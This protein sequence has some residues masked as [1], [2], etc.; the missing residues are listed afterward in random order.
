MI[1]SAQPQPTA[2]GRDPV[3]TQRR[4]REAP[5]RVNP[6]A[7]QCHASWILRLL[8]SPNGAA[9]ATSLIDWE[10]LLHTARSNGVLVRTAE[11]LATLGARVP[12]TFA[13]A[14][15]LERARVHST[16]ELVRHVSQTCEAHGVEF[17]FPKLFQD[18]PDMGDDVDLLVLDRSSRVDRWIVA[19][20]ETSAARRDLGEWMAGTVTYAIR[21]CP[22]PL[23]VQHGRL[24]V[25]GE[26]NAFP[27][28]LMQNQRRIIV[29][30]AEFFAPPPEQQ[31]VL[32]GLQRVAGRRRI[33]LCDV[34]FTITAICRDPLDWDWIIGLARQHGV[35]LGLSCYLSYVD[36]IY[37][38]VF[39]HE[40]LPAAVRRALV[41]AGWGRVEFRQ[42]GYRFPLF[43][44]NRRLYLEQLGTR[45]ADADWAGAG[46][47][48]LIPVVA[49]WR[50]L[51]GLARS[52]TQ[53]KQLP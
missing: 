50:G 18:Y 42:G 22:S 11:R 51:R 37:G 7:E 12:E 32:Q 52:R 2:P 46:R 27:E 53:P 5:R 31:L 15:A 9:D 36:Q 13:D 47:L 20:L 33:A 49:A 17:V 23:D 41:L 39:G 35:F 48:G 26:H 43:R 14:V 40:L 21:D 34:V 29:D 4:D 28:V 16:L 3:T 30:V 38:E 25:V 1:E 8:L 44:V 45:M 10:L 24:G 6:Q 19:G